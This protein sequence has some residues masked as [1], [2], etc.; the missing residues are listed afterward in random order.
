MIY[1][2][3]YV[4]ASIVL[5]DFYYDDPVCKNLIKDPSIVQ[6]AIQILKNLNYNIIPLF[7]FAKC[8][9][10]DL[11]IMCQKSRPNKFRKKSLRSHRSKS[12]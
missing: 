7:G 2:G 8:P 12:V 5:I 4:L 6:I 3:C 9:C 11:K 1:A 10:Q